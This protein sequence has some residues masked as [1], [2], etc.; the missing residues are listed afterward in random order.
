M[1]PVPGRSLVR[2]AG[3]AARVCVAAWVAGCLSGT[4]PPPPR[5]CGA[6]CPPGP[7]ASCGASVG[8]GVGVAPG[9]AVPAIDPA[10]AWPNVPS[11]LA[12]VSDESFD[13]LTEHGWIT[14]QRNV[15]NGSGATLALD[16]NAP[17]SPPGVIQYT[18][19]DGFP[20]GSTPAVTYYDLATPV[21]EA[22]F[23][24]WWK[25][26]SRWQ[27]NV[28]SG[29]N[30]LA[31]L[32]TQQTAVHGEMAMIMFGTDS[33]PYTLQVVTEFPGDVR[34]LPPNLTPALVT[35][36][37]WHRVEW[38]ARF[39]STDSTRDGALRWWLDGVPQGGYADLLMPDDPGFKEFQIAPTW[40]GVVGTKSERDFFCYDHAHLSIPA[41][42]SEPFTP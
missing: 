29:V 36:G 28:E 14:L 17:L 7:P 3:R 12:T 21:K 37:A 20:A 32:L 9:A 11:G 30:K 23:G 41:A 25:P 6:N 18:Y 13:A 8:A 40:G 16:P 27:N 35:L 15:I 24:F 2:A 42:V 5:G 10:S 39:S 1:D 26:S 31:F 19:A 22:Y 38:Y 4:G 33:G 34:R